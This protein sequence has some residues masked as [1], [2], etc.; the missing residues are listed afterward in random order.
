MAV[1]AWWWLAAQ[2]KHPDPRRATGLLT[3]LAILWAEAPDIAGMLGKDAPEHWA[4][5]LI[6]GGG[7]IVPLD[8]LAAQTGPA[9]L[10]GLRYLVI[11]QPRPLAPQENVALDAWVRGGG[12]LLLFADPLLTEA[13]IH[14]LGDK[15]RPQDT[16]LLDPILNHWGLRLEFDSEDEFKEGPTLMMG[17]TVPVNVPGRLIATQPACRTWDQGELAICRI[18]KGRVT[19]LADAAVLEQDD[20]DG[21]RARAL[22]ALLK[23]AFSDR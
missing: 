5:T 13:S 4:R 17:M 18:G 10:A 9:P 7:R 16:V 11:A 6:A 21:A 15:R 22:S 20:P 14:G 23:T 3:S 1:L 19:V 12:R 2:A 8:T